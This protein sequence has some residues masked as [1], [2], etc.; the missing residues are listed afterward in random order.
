[1]SAARSTSTSRTDIINQEIRRNKAERY[2]EVGVRHAADNY[3]RVICKEKTGIDS[4]D[5]DKSPGLLRQDSD[6]FFMVTVNKFDV[7]FIDGDH[8]YDQCQRDLKNALKHL[9]RGGVIILHDCLPTC[10]AEALPE[11]PNTG[12]AWCGEVWR[13]FLGVM[14]RKD[15]CATLVPSDHGVG[16]VKR[17]RKQGAVCVGAEAK[18]WTSTTAATLRQGATHNGGGK[19]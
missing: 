1:M 16:I 19:A 7:I 17:G 11:K 10:A 18:A 14:Q 2:L 6:T 4:R 12:K 8:R 13:V 3:D 15:L 9:R 5:Q